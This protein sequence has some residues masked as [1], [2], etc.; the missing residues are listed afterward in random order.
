MFTARM[1]AVDST[2]L[3][4]CYL[5]DVVWE[6]IEPDSVNKLSHL[7]A[8]LMY[9]KVV[10]ITTWRSSCCKLAKTVLTNARTGMRHVAEHTASLILCCADTHLIPRLHSHNS[11]ATFADFGR[12]VCDIIQEIIS[13]CHNNI[14]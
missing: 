7:S 11:Q 6:L 8:H 12:S 2:L 9:S 4:V 1:T 10:T 14:N 13:E 5:S 3:L